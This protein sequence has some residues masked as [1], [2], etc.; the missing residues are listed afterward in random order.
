MLSRV[1]FG[2]GFFDK[3][4]EPRRPSQSTASSR[5]RLAAITGLTKALG[6]ET[7]FTY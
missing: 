1:D 2:K 5:V 6:L 4:Y 7:Q 3:T